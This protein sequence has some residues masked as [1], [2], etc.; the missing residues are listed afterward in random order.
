VTKNGKHK[1][2]KQRIEEIPT[3]DLVGSIR[4]EL[5]KARVKQEEIEAKRKKK[6]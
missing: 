1:P 5:E 2:E 4:R 6:R 3:R